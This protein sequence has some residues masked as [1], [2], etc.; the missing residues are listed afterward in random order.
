M[1]ARIPIFL[2]L[3]LV[4]WLAVAP[5]FAASHDLEHLDPAS[6]GESECAAYH[7]GERHDGVPLPEAFSLVPRLSAEERSCAVTVFAIVEQRQSAAPRG[8]PANV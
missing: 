3:L 5:A 1:V 7:H 6:V 8:P 2:R 4:A